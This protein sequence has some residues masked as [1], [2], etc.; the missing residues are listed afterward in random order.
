[1]FR[2]LCIACARI[3]AGDLHL[4]G[5]AKLTFSVQDTATGFVDVAGNLKVQS[6][7]TVLLTTGTAFVPTDQRVV[8]LQYRM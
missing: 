5:D 2:W 1:M 6:T 3:G 4:S 7:I 8:L